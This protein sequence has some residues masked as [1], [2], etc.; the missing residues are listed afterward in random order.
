MMAM[1]TG[2]EAVEKMLQSP[3]QRVATSYSTPQQQRL[4]N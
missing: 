4:Q 1:I 2:K 3:S